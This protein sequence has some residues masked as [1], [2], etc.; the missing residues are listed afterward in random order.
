[1][2]YLIV[3]T[4]L[5]C[6]V[7]ACG[8]DLIVAT[9]GDSLKCKIVEVKP[10]EIQFRFGAGGMIAI[11]RNEVASYQYNFAP[12]AP[13][14]RDTRTNPVDDA[15]VHASPKE[16]EKDFLPFYV[17]LVG[18]H[19]DIP[20]IGFNAAYFFNQCAGLGFALHH[21]YWSSDAG[22]RH[23]YTFFGPVFYGHWG[24]HNGKFYFPTNFGL[25]RLS[26]KENSW[27]DSTTGFGY[28][29]SVG[30][31]CRLTNLISI[32]LNGEIAKDFYNEMYLMGGFAVNLN[33]HF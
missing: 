25:V 11:P 23:T 8:Q 5:L 10:D 1:M 4:F 22:N 15:P 17:G 18:G 7:I 14:I 27:E 30:A 19:G 26:Y 3:I 32:G 9:S 21:Q 28:F 6:P 13:T 33:F 31:A 24:K 20:L 12:V 16:K 29:V 2:K